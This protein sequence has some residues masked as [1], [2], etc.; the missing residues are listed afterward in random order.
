MAAAQRRTVLTRSVRAAP[1]ADVDDDDDERAA[2]VPGGPGAEAVRADLSK[3]GVAYVW[4]T[5]EPNELDCY[6]LTQWAWRQA[7]VQLGGDTYTQVTQPVSAPPGEVRA[8]DL[9]FSRSSY[10]GRGRGHVRLAISATQVV[11]APQTGD[12]VHIAP[13]SSS[14]VARTSVASTPR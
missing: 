14:Y 4:G 5:K 13:M 7:G 2:S 9:A 3:R 12:V 10:D 11:H 1:D 8:G 6:G